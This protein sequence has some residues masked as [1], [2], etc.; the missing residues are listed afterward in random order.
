MNAINASTAAAA[1]TPIPP[2]APTESPPLGF[3]GVEDV[4]VAGGEVLVEDGGAV[5][6]VEDEGADEVVEEILEVEVGPI[7]GASVIADE[8]PQQLILFLPQQKTFMDVLQ[9]V[10]IAFPLVS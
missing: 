7:I 10:R 6:V 1:P 3:G 9:G 2:F 5:E 4:V 8:V